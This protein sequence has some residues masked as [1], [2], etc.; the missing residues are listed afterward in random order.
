MITP[1]Y[2]DPRCRTAEEH[3]RR[4][5]EEHGNTPE[6]RARDMMERAGDEHAQSR[7]SGEV[8]EIANLIHL[9]DRLERMG[10]LTKRNGIYEE[11]GQ[12]LI[13]RHV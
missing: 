3:E 2:H 5:E 9:V 4:T 1:C 10:I 12:Y 13:R 11:H 6:Q 8:I 7:S